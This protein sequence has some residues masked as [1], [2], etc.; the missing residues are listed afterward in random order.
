MKKIVLL[1]MVGLCVTGTVFAQSKKDADKTA[2]GEAKQQVV[3]K[4]IFAYQKEL[5]LTDKQVQDLKDKLSDFQKY[6]IEQRKTLVNLQKEL[7]EMIANRAVLKLIK[8][9]LE[10]IAHVQ[11]DTGYFDV[12]TSRKIEEELTPAQLEKWKGIQGEARKQNEQAIKKAQEQTKAEQL[13][14]D[15]TEK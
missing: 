9:K 7:N 1:V 4:T 3:V 10:Q 15:K 11:A 8:E 14:K 13:N 12:E 6:L 5:S 2:T